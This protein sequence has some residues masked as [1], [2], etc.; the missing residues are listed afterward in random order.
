VATCA[1]NSQFWDRIEKRG[2]SFPGGILKNAGRFHFAR[3]ESGIVGGSTGEIE[4]LRSSRNLIGGRRFCG[5]FAAVPRTC[6]HPP[7]QDKT[8]KSGVKVQ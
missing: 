2:A 6:E 4:N 8:V 7:A 3:K 5:V 1:P